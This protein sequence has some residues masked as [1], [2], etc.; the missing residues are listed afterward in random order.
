MYDCLEAIHSHHGLHTE[1]LINILHADVQRAAL[2]LDTT[3]FAMDE[4]SWVIM[5]AE[6]GQLP[7]AVPEFDSKVSLQQII[8]EMKEALA[9][10]YVIPTPGTPPENTASSNRTVPSYHGCPPRPLYPKHRC[11]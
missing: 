1:D 2:T 8:A 3:M 11:H 6:L 10:L 9:A 5:E 7:Q 4:P